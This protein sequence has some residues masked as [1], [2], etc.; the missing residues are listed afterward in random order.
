M[1]NCL[2]GGCSER[3]RAGYFDCIGAC[4]DAVNAGLAACDATANTC[5]T[6]YYQGCGQCT[7]PSDPPPGNGPVANPDSAPDPDPEP[8]VPPANPGIPSPLAPPRYERPEYHSLTCS[9]GSNLACLNPNSNTKLVQ[10]PLGAPNGCGPAGDGY[11]KYLSQFLA[12]TVPQLRSVCNTHDNCFGTCSFM[13]DRGVI[14]C[15]P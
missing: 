15:R 3:F 14:G 13:P 2:S 6:T 5:R 9:A 11:E 7:S 12:F 8:S 4:I 10:K 1:R